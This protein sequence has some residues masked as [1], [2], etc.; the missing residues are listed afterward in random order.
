MGNEQDKY[1]GWSNEEWAQLSPD[2]KDDV[3]EAAIYLKKAGLDFPIILTDDLA[4]SV[5]SASIVMSILGIKKSEVDKRLRPLNVGDYTGKS[6]KDH[7]LEEYAKDKSKKIPGGESMN[8]FDNRLAKI[9]SDMLEL[10]IKLKKPILFIGHGS[11]IS[12]LHNAVSKNT[13]VG[14]E[15][16][17]SP[18][19]VLVFSSEGFFPVLKQ[20]AAEGEKSPISDGTALSGFVTDEENRPPR[21]CW[22]CR[23]AIEDA[24]RKLSCIHPLVQIDP[25][26]QSRRNPDG[27][28]KIKDRDCCNNFRNKVST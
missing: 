27:S 11:T 13:K 7:P 24:D 14:Y 4:R 1:R 16:L 20:Q 12:F 9:T 23:S 28:I 5:E 6:K 17:V 2:G 18:G 26:L 10:V 15:G 8:Q 21:E 25:Q 3:R 22:N 19:G